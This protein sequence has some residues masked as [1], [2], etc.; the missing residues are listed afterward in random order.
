ML[1]MDSEPE[2]EASRLA[3]EAAMQAVIILDWDDTLCPTT[4]AMRLGSYG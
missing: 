1:A 4:W 2:H 3:S